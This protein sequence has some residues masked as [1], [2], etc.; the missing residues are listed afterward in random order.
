MTRTWT[1]VF[2]VVSVAGCG[3]DPCREYS[4]YTCEQ[5]EDQTYNV[6][7]YDVSRGSGLDQELY[8][9]E[10]NGLEGCGTIAYA[11]ADTR[12]D[13]REGDWSYICCLQTEQSSCAEKHR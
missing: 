7:Y 11:V 8:L 9:G 2:V 13:E 6:Y 10:A 12:A 3:S 4:A 5:L 1:A